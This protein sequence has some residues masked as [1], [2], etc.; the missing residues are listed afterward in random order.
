MPDCKQV[1]KKLRGNEKKLKSDISELQIVLRVSQNA[2]VT[3]D[4]VMT[5]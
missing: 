4:L 3:L 5:A 2:K 1:N